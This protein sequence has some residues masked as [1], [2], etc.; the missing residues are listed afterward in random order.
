MKHG[1][2][3]SS[4]RPGDEPRHYQSVNHAINLV[5]GKYVGV[6][7]VVCS[8]VDE[9]I[10]AGETHAHQKENAKKSADSSGHNALLK[11]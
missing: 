9:I 6:P 10:P 1:A 8:I 4:Y 11:C 5:A 2:N 3:N 7:G